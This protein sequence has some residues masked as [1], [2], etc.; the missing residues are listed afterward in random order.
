M[1]FNLSSPAFADGG[2]IPERHTADGADLSPPLIWSDPPAGTAS[3]ALILD[4]PDAPPGV[5]VHWVLYD[6]PAEARELPEGVPP[7]GHLADGSRQGASWGVER[8]E[9]VGYGGPSPPPGSPHRYVLQLIALDRRLDLPA[10]LTAH[11]LRRAIRGHVLGEARLHGFYG[12]T[13]G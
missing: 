6:L 1:A 3:F 8:F 11:Q 5:W 10:G 2:T 4:D 13:Q 7:G 12:R 9:R